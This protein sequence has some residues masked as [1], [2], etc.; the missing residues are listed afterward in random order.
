VALEEENGE[1]MLYVCEPPSD[2]DYA[3][4]VA[5]KQMVMELDEETWRR[6]I[7]VF[8]IKTSKI[9]TRPKAMTKLGAKWYG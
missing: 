2:D 5:K 4:G 9:P 3:Q 7:E 8:D 1:P 6:A